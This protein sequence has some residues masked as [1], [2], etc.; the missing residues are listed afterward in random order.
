LHHWCIWPTDYDALL[1]KAERLGYVTLQ[2]GGTGRGRFA[3]LWD[4]AAN[5]D[6]VLEVTESTP[7]RRAFQRLVAVAG[8]NWDGADPIRTSWSIPDEA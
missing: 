8:V 5:T 6:I 1:G 7:T 2:D 3:Y 4:D